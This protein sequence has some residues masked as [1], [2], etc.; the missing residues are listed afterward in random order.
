MFPMKN[1]FPRTTEKRLFP[2]KIQ[3]LYTVLEECMNMEQA[4]LNGDYYD[5][6]NVYHDLKTHAME[7]TR[8]QLS[9]KVMCHYMSTIPQP[10]KCCGKMFE[11]VQYWYDQIKQYTWLKLIELLAVETLCLLQN[12]VEDIVLEYI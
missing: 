12:A 10:D 3:R 4:K 9:C 11:V 6:Y 2:S 7:F 1:M 8:E 5:T